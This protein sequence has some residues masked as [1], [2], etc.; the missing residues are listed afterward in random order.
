M[1]LPRKTFSSPSIADKCFVPVSNIL[2]NI[3]AP[4]TVTGRI[5]WISDI[6]FEQTLKA[7]ENHKI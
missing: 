6:D 4:A 3:T 5:Y 7:Y 2:C 1:D